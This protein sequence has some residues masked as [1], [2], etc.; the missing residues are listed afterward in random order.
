MEYSAEENKEMIEQELE[1]LRMTLNSQEYQETID[2]TLSDRY[3]ATIDLKIMPQY[4]QE[5]VMLK[6]TGMDHIFYAKRV[7]LVKV[8][9]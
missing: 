5:Q 8:I 4:D 2:S 7:P 1:A 6:V 3:Y 9:I